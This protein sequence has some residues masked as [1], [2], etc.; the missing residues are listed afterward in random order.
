MVIGRLGRECVAANSISSVMFQLAGVVVFGVSSAA[1]AIT[2]NTIGTGDYAL[3][4]KRAGKLVVIA[5]MVGL[6]ASGLIFAIRPV[7]INFYQISDLARQYAFEITAVT[8]TYAFFSAISMITMMGVLRG[9]GDT[10]FVMVADV[11][12]MWCIAIPFG[13]LAGLVWHWPVPVV[14]GILK[15]EDLFKSGIAVLRIRSG[16]WVRDITQA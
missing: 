2:G 11:V 15:C 1:S 12:F 8:G 9:G 16:R 13:A 5:G 4:K 10:R 3:A 7:L 6:V 14:Y